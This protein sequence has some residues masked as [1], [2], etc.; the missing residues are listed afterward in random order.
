MKEFIKDQLKVEASGSRHLMGIA[1]ANAVAKKIIELL[2]AKQFVN[3]IFAAAP[4]QNEFLDELLKLEIDWTRVRA[5]H[6]DEY[7]NLDVDAP[8]G[9]GN[10]LRERLFGKVPFKA[11]HYLNGNAANAEQEC[12]RYA[13]LLNQFPPDVVCLGIGE[14]TH[15]AFNDP[16]VADFNDPLLVKI[17]DLD[18]A[19][20]VQQV[21][22]G[23]FARIEDVPTHALTLTIPALLNTPFA[24]A[25]VPGEKKADAVKHTLNAAISEI[26][27]S[28]ILRRH[29]D[30]T[31]FVDD[32]S[33]AYI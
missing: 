27:P 20:R 8:Q 6:M 25:I 12:L 28:T 4:S 32:K 16:H 15:L 9:F 31:L 22:D 24:F 26:Y 33:G 29:P 3:I 19:C 10:F 7:L 13:D 23:C 11:V 18:N 14:N 1:A 5:F 2:K 30:A 17:V 21:N